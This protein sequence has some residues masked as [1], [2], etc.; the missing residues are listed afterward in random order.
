[1]NPEAVQK[2]RLCENCGSLVT[3]VPGILSAPSKPRYIYWNL[4]NH[5]GN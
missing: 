5:D 2:V 1:M 4:G 3:Q